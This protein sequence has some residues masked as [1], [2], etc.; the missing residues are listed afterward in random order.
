MDHFSSFEAFAI[1]AFATGLAELLNARFL[2]LPS[3]MGLV[4][5][6]LLVVGIALLLEVTGVHAV[7][8]IEHMLPKNS[9]FKKYLIDSCLAFLLY[10][11]A[12]SVDQ[13]TLR[14]HL[15]PVLF[16]ATIGVVISTVFVALACWGIC[17]VRGVDFVFPAALIF[18]A[19]ISPTDALAVNPLLERISGKRSWKSIISGESLF[20][21]AMALLLFVVFTKFAISGKLETSSG[22]ML[23]FLREAGI[24]I[25]VGLGTAAIATAVV[26]IAPNRTKLGRI[27]IS[28][29]LAAGSYALATRFE[30]S[31]PIA[32]V[33]AGLALVF[34]LKKLKTVKPMEEVALFWRLVEQML[35]AL[36]FFLIGLEVLTVNWSWFL[37]G[38]AAM[39]WIVVLVARFITVLVGYGSLA[40]MIDVGKVRNFIFPMTLAGVRGAI[41]IALALSLPVASKFPYRDH[42][43]VMTFGAV[44][45]GLL[46]QGGALILM[47]DPLQKAEESS[48][49][50]RKPFRNLLSSDFWRHRMKKYF[51]RHRNKNQS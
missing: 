34:T 30:A 11:A 19:I 32:V 4:V 41:S 7:E 46:V 26:M 49:R 2:K 15:F 1:L 28:M 6:S 37:V 12:I 16:F 14:K 24:A 39:G 40:V 29:S 50:L 20:N 9:D 10:A 27:L 33:T 23:E 36:F 44:V 47:A 18:G 43:I 38:M 45:I 5:M 13:R 31:G 25:G 17:E 51:L 3:A 42:I 35:A 8:S 48:L 21:D 22:L